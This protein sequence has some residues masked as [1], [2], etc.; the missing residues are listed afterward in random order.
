MVMGCGGVLEWVAGVFSSM[1]S[2]RWERKIVFGFGMIDGV[3]TFH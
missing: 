2:M 3:G 1:C